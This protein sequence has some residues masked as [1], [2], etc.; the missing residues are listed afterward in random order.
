MTFIVA[1]D[2]CLRSI[3]DFSDKTARISI[4]ICK[5]SNIYAGLSFEMRHKRKHLLLIS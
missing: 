1:Q 3:D 2:H 5:N 4:Y